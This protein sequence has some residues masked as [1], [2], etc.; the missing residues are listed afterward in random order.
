ML[1]KKDYAYFTSSESINQF[2]GRQNFIPENRQVNN[3]QKNFLNTRQDYK[4]SPNY[5]INDK[6]ENIKNNKN[7]SSITIKH[8]SNIE[9][10]R[11]NNINN[12]NSNNNKKY[13]SDNKKYSSYNKNNDETSNGDLGSLDD[14]SLNGL[15][16]KNKNN[17]KVRNYSKNDTKISN[18]RQNKKM[19]ELNDKVIIDDYSDYDNIKSLNSMD[20][21]LSNVVSMVE[22][23]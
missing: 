4:Q 12:S 14:I 6:L 15:N 9:Q 2:N 1:F 20:N 19:D 10:K 17:Q 16:N 5:N 22:K 8:N 13:S 23:D 7:N 11:Y 21:T 3:H 18:I